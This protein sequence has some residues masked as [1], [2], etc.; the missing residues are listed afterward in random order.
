[1]TDDRVEKT[2]AEKLSETGLTAGGA[3]TTEQALDKV[4]DGVEELSHEAQGA[5]GLSEEITD[6][7]HAGEEAAKGGRSAG[8]ADLEVLAEDGEGLNESLHALFGLGIS[9]VIDDL[10][11]AMGLEKKK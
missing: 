6:E 5:L 11:Y 8:D 2:A 10:L 1:M 4:Q 3:T 9:M 7:G